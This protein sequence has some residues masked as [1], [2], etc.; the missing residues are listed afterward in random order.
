[1]ESVEVS[2]M[3]RESFSTEKHPAGICY[4]LSLVARRSLSNWVSPMMGEEFSIR[5]R[6]RAQK[7]ELDEQEMTTKAKDS[8]S[9]RSNKYSFEY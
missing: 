7:S 1:M 6:A 8:S 5:C 9:N 3:K 2:S 4:C